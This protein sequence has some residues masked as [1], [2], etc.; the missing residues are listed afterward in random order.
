MGSRAF[1]FITRN[2]VISQFSKLTG[3]MSWVSAAIAIVVCDHTQKAFGL[4][5]SE[6]SE[7]SQGADPWMK[8]D[9][10]E[11]TEAEQYC[12]NSFCNR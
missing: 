9:N 4:L 11:I 1:N 3:G 10:G 2:S 12:F 7:K 5:L 8:D 6:R